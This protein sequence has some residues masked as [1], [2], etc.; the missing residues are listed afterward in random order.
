MP[1][2][3]PATAQPPSRPLAGIGVVITR[4]AGTAGPLVRQVRA[5]GGLPVAV[6]GLS[7]R[8]IAGAETR[9]AL[10]AALGDELVIF[11]SPAAVRFAAKLAP[12]RTAAT[13][14]AVG[15]GTAAALRV[16][17]IAAHVP[18]QR[19]DSE[20]LLALDVVGELDG[21]RVALVGAPGGRGVLRR[22]LAGRGARLREVHVYRR[23][24]PRLDRRHIEPLLALP[25]RSA[26]L[27]SSAEALEHLRHGLPGPAWERLR[28][29]LVVVSSERLR[30]V[31]KEAGF[32]GIQVAAS[33]M[34][35]DMLQAVGEYVFTCG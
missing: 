22:E 7:L 10:L 18:A 12:L 4:P 27:I 30:E 28:H 26:V 2:N 29:A 14:V 31:A 33:A 3:A 20:G 15:Q 16:H 25:A 9:D 34:P 23:V 8:A 6:P 32:A 21:R 19:Q 24:A 35:A 5:L 11:T 17:E 1:T 13:V